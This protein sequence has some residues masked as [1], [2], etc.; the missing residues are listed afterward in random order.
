V[1]IQSHQSF[2]H[3]LRAQIVRDWRRPL[4]GVIALSVILLATTWTVTW[5]WLEHEQE[6]LA[7]S[8]QARQESLAVII[9]ENF[10]RALD[11]AQIFFQWRHPNGSMAIE[12]I[13][14]SA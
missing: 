6:L 7:R 5:H 8:S 9:S 13:P 2:G 11:Q 10:N 14:R 1:T 4:L 3:T 12:A